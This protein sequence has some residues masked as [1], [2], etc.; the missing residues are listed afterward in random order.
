M[1]KQQK[2]KAARRAARILQKE[3]AQQ[4]AVIVTDTPPDLG[5]SV[6]EIVDTKDKFG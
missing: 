5:V 6:A 4:Q 1:G 3:E 2:L